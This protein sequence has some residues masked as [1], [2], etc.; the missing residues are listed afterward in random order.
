[1]ACAAIS[2]PFLNLNARKEQVELMKAHRL[3]QE[4]I[5][6]K[7]QELANL[8]IN[9]EKLKGETLKQ[10][11]ETLGLHKPA[12]EQI[13]V[14]DVPNNNFQFRYT[15]QKDTND[16]PSTASAIIQDTLKPNTTNTS[17]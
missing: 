9:V 4:D 1:M 3:L 16:K 5:Q 10:H 14:I 12:Q 6:I 7:D 8:L 17:Y 11:A 2:I 13:V 15:A